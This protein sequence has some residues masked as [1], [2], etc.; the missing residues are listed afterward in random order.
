MLANARS[1][2]GTEL[3]CKML[4]CT[5]SA[6]AASLTSF[7]CASE[8]FFGGIEE[9][10]DQNNGDRNQLAQEPKSLR[11]QLGGEEVHSGGVAVAVG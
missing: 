4:S 7:D 11:L 1:I 6:P 2:S 5:P 8:S 9:H 3:A 10:R